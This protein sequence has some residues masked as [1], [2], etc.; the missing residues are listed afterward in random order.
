MKGFPNCP[1]IA[2]IWEEILKASDLEGADP[3]H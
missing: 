1:A 3:K 2:R